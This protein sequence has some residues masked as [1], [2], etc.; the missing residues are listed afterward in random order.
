MSLL[1]L[2]GVHR[3]SVASVARRGDHLVGLCEQ[4]AR[5]LTKTAQSKWEA[6]EPLYAKRPAGLNG[7]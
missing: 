7:G 1:C 5:P 3:P 2:F 4:C 6:A